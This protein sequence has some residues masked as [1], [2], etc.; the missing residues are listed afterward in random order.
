MLL[1]VTEGRAPLFSWRVAA[2]ALSYLMF[3]VGA[4]IPALIS[5][6]LK[7]IP[8]NDERRQRITRRVIRGLCRFYVAVMEG[9]GLYRL[10]FINRHRDLI[11]GQLIVANH[12]MLLDA[13]FIMAFLPN[14]CCIAKPALA[15]NPFTGLTLKQAGFLIS[16][17]MDLVERV[18]AKIQNGEN[19]LIFPEGTRSRY[20]TE[21][22]FK[23]GAANLAVLGECPI[24]PVVL[25][26]TPSVLQKH[27]KWYDL[28]DQRCD[29]RLT[30]EPSMRV[31]ECIDVSLP[32]TRQYR[33]LTD[34]LRQFF[35]QRLS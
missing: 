12:P 24:L 17:E 33:A 15:R 1:R 8:M 16:E 29:I 20:D 11:A 13:I 22:A 14:V 34:Y 2:A 27:Q 30:V 7:I 18:T 32:R 9:L 23:R 5:L 10:T 28:P 4:S 6:F 19:V 21:L 25:S 31:A 3:A 26:S 35:L